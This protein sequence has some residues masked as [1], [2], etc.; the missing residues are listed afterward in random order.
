LVD[1][2]GTRAQV[3]DRRGTLEDMA[4]PDLRSVDIRGWLATQLRGRVVGPDAAQRAVTLFDA[5]GPRWF[6]PDAPIRR[7]HADASM[8]IGGMRALLFQSLH[9]LAMA[10]VAQH[11]NYRADPWGRLQR[12][13]DFL[14][15]TTFGPV[16]EAERAVA[17]VHQV[18]KR[19]T[20]VASDGRPYEANDPHLLRWVHLAEADSFLTA[21]DRYGSDRLTPAEK[22]HYLRDSAVIARALGVVA[23]PESVQALR[24]QL[25]E[26]RSEL[27]GT[28]EARDAA[29]YL[30]FR[31]PLPVLARPAYGLIAGA[32]VALLPVWARWSLRL[33]VLPVAD[34]FTVRPAG[35][36]VTR[37]LRWAMSPHPSEQPAPR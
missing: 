30:V 11:S 24:D 15:A 4:A 14:A 7:V 18:H 31:P 27:R 35:E 8:F 16:A 28:P 19:V 32:A 6:E 20:G 29:K 23:P 13:A 10:G 33:P 12:T 1:S 2:I 17:I 34:D 36:V 3:S 26:Y 21:H 25:Q 22:D 9:P 37:T 5:T